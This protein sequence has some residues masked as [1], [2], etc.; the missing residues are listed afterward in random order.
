MITNFEEITQELTADEMVLCRQIV[1]GLRTKTKDNPIKSD[2]I[3]N[4]MN[5][6]NP[7]NKLTGARLRKIINYIR[8]NGILPVIATSNGYYT[9]NDIRG[10]LTRRDPPIERTD[11]AGRQRLIQAKG[12]ADG[13]RPI[14][15]L[16]L[17]GVG[18]A[19]GM[20]ARGHV[21]QHRRQ[22]LRGPRVYR[23]RP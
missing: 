19:Q 14:A 4:K 22:A 2:E 18:Q 11:D 21:R 5:Q 1:L 6:A 20:D 8:S 16:H 10:H 13:Q 15:D 23:G 9:S 7:K 17:G 12:V 3:V